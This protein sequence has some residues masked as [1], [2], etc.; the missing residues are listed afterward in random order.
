[1]GLKVVTSA[2]EGGYPPVDP[3]CSGD[4]LPPPSCRDEAS[5]ARRL[6]ICREAWRADP[7]LFEGTDRILTAPLAGTTFGMVVGLNP[8]SPAPVGGA[9]F[10][11]DEA[12]AGTGRSYAI[13]TFADGAD[14]GEVLLVGSPTRIT[15]GVSHVH[16]TSPGSPVLTAEMAVFEN[17]D[18]DN[19]TFRSAP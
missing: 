8:V 9:Q 17:L 2:S 14:S 10:F 19:V 12:L 3:D 18:E 6:A 16:L 4:G 15:R 5:N 7:A 11:V 1:M 13:H